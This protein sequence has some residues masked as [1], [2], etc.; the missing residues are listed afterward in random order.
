MEKSKGEPLAA[1]TPPPGQGPS[2]TLFGPEP[3]IGTTA[4]CFVACTYE[5]CACATAPTELPWKKGKAGGSEAVRTRPNWTQETAEKRVKAGEKRGVAREMPA[6]MRGQRQQSSRLTTG[7][8]HK[9]S[10]NKM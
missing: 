1:P 3:L 9:F 7:P 5:A 2:F 4:R 6:V 10:K 8:N